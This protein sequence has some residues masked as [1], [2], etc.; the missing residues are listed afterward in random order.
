[1]RR[2]Q[3]R[4]RRVVAQKV[5]ATPKTTRSREATGPARQSAPYEQQERQRLQRNKPEQ[6]LRETQGRNDASTSRA[7][8]RMSAAKQ[9]NMKTE[10]ILKDD[11]NH[12]LSSFNKHTTTQSISQAHRIAHEQTRNIKS[13][14]TT[15]NA[16][17]MSHLGAS[18]RG[19][20]ICA[21]RYIQT[22]PVLCRETAQGLQKNRRRCRGGRQCSLRHGRALG[23]PTVASRRR[24]QCRQRIV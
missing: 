17:H 3:R 6:A 8:S 16:H 23:S 11:K 15:V 2:R 9:H 7:A 24:S 18:A 4:R 10:D 19:P 1:M 22:K 5:A 21:T 12:S 14:H 20:Q 13:T